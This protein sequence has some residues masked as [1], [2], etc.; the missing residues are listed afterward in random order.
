MLNKQIGTLSFTN[1]FI[2]Q[3]QGDE[4][5]TDSGPLANPTPPPD[6]DL[7]QLRGDRIGDTVYSGRWCIQTVMKLMRVSCV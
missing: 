1:Y 3:D 7:D 4:R 6:V 5:K 2:E